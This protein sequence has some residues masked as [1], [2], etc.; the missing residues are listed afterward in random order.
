MWIETLEEMR[1][2]YA[3]LEK[4]ALVRRHRELANMTRGIARRGVYSTME[5]NPW[6]ELA[7]IE[8]EMHEIAVKLGW[9]EDEEE[10]E[11]E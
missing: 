2:S 8:D 10:E 11:D 9:E 6:D 1:E 7:D 5:Y 4:A 3:K